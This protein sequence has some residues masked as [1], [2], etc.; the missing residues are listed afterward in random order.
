MINRDKIIKSIAFVVPLIIL[1]IAIVN[2]HLALSPNLEVGTF[3][4]ER[5]VISNT[6]IIDLEGVDLNQTVFGPE[7]GIYQT[8]T[9]Y[10]FT[11]Q[12]YNSGGGVARDVSIKSRGS[13][14]EN[15]K[16][17]KTYVYVGE[18]LDSNLLDV[19]EDEYDIGLLGSDKSYTFKF[20]VSIIFEESVDELVII[21]VDS[22]NAGNHMRHILFK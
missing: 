10:N 16:I 7:D 18:P 15:I 12:V 11:Y 13:P 20:I 8:H 9:N 19:V 5:I 14:S 4:V 6:L 21:D 17:Q 2:L 3:P 22:S 1:S